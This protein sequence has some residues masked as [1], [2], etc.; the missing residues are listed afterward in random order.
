MTVVIFTTVLIIAA[1]LI[2]VIALRTN[3]S[4][5]EDPLPRRMFAM[6]TSEEL[7]PSEHQAKTPTMPPEL[8]DHYN[9]TRLVLMVRDPDWLYAYWEVGDGH[10]DNL[11]RHHG[12]A[13]SRDNLTLRVFEMQGQMQYFD[14]N[15]GGLARDW[16]IRV[17]K[18][19]TPFYCQ[20][21]F[22]YHQDFITLAVS[23]TVVTPRDSLSH[24]FDEEWMLVND[25]EQRLLKRLGEFPLDLTSPF[26]FRKEG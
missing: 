12:G 4:R 23:N 2:A 8:P 5:T 14:I 24:L 26:M 19:Q 10:W 1:V 16:H 15:V 22:K 18:S 9:D 3:L 17:S 6:E 25:H 20:L 13:A 11:V 7:V 21:G